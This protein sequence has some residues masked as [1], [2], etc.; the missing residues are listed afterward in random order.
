MQPICFYPIRADRR[1]QISCSRASLHTFHVRDPEATNQVYRL[2]VRRCQIVTSEAILVA[3]R[4]TLPIEGASKPQ[5]GLGSSG[6]RL[7]WIIF[8]RH[9]YSIR[10]FEL[11]QFPHLQILLRRF[12]EVC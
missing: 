1:S 11:R 12:Q 9:S 3:T 10:S 8:S 4:E 7:C 6:R 2:S 5:G